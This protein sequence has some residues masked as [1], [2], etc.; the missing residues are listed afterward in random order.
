VVA[1][2][3]SL[4]SEIKQDNGCAALSSRPR[5]T[6]GNLWELVRS[7]KATDTTRL[8]GRQ[9]DGPLATMQVDVV[10]VETNQG[11]VMSLQRQKKK[12]TKV[13]IKSSHIVHHRMTVAAG[14]VVF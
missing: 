1:Q 2:E 13:L 10:K 4:L 3:R 6:M 14:V 8:E 7:W 12:K 11:S 5:M 9:T